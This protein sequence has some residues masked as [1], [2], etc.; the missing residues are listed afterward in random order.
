M[1]GVPITSLLYGNIEHKLHAC[2]GSLSPHLHCCGRCPLANLLP[3]ESI[4]GSLYLCILWDGHFLDV[5]GCPL[6]IR[7]LRFLFLYSSTEGSCRL[8][9]FKVDS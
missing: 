9:S 6:S 8:S 5:H 7:G 1:V 4:R 3:Y 2:R